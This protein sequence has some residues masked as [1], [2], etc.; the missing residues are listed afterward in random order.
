MEDTTRQDYLPYQR[1]RGHPKLTIAKV[2]LVVSLDNPWLAASPDDRVTDPDDPQP[3]GLVEYKNPFVA[4]QLTLSEA[5]DLSTFC[6][7]KKET[8]GKTTYKLK[9]RHDYYYQ[10]QCQLYCDNKDWCDFV[11]RTEKEL[12]VERFYRNVEWWGEQIPK[13]RTFYF[14]ALLPQLACPRH[15]KGGIREPTP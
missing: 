5:C 10:V 12:H 6:L 2:G 7:Q 13:L 8:D 14:E 4:R 15:H 9:Q 1:E 3:L 11:V